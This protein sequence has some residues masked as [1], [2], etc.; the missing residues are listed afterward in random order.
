M[1]SRCRNSI[2]PASDLLTCAAAFA[3]VLL[4]LGDARSA[5]EVGPGKTHGTI[6]EAWVA[7]TAGD[8]IRVY[9]KAG[10]AA[11]RQVALLLRS[12]Q[13]ITISADTTG[14]ARVMLDGEGY[15][16][17]G[18][19]PVPRAMFQFDPGSD[20][21]VVENFEIRNCHNDSCNGAGFRINQA[22]GITV[23]NCHVHHCDMGIMS[24]GSVADN[25]ASDQLVEN[26]VFND[27]GNDLHAG[28]NHNF[29]VGG[30]SI[31]IRG[32]EVFNAT[33]G[34]NIKSRAHLTIVEGCY[35][36]DSPNREFDFVDAAGN[37]DAAGS[38]ALI[39]GCTIV[40]ANP[41]TGNKAV[42]HF[43]QDGGSDHTGTLHILSCTI[44]TP[45][46]SAVVDLSAPGAGVRMHNTIVARGSV[47][48]LKD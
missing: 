30:T 41:I 25:S 23:R 40:K 4:P 21:S 32:C 14:G 12:K 9:P 20:G 17:S 1:I 24:N 42:I 35:V 27:N 33:T 15:S 10:G 18:S 26:S 38:H 31:V 48:R 28:F 46:T 3:F 22:N 8:T 39:S 19:L 6:E 44:L 37:T 45:Y 36:H 43:G 29:Y 5:L 13:N 16:Y 34:H 2:A 7:A 11:Y 47:P